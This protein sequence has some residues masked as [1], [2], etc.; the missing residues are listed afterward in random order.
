MSEHGFRLYN[1]LAWLWPLWNF[2][3]DPG[4]VA[5]AENVTRLIGKYSRIPARTL[6]NVACGGGTNAYNLK[7]HFEVIGVDISRPMLDL[8]KRLNPDC[9]F[10]LA[11]MRSFSLGRQF[12]AVFIDDGITDI[13]DR[14]DLAAVFRTAFE[15]LRPGGV[16]V[17]GPDHVKETFRQ[18]C[19]RISEADSPDKPASIE[20][21]F[22]E[23]DYDPDPTD[24]TYEFTLIYLIREN[25]VLRIETDHS[26]D[27]LFS[28]D[29]WRTMLQ[30]TGFEVHEE[31]NAG[32]SS[33]DPRSEAPV[34]VCTKPVNDEAG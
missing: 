13:S 5:W 23:N 27:G 6:L 20:V 10:V 12:D 11:D 9:E 7:R 16:M 2:P 14:A 24:D 28:L 25:G 17:G 19:T 4:Y 29:T 32:A 31:A 21:T 33:D 30:E 3:S 15:H 1:D 26:I 18:N 22:V 8:A 34:F